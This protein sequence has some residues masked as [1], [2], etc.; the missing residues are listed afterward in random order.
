MT[1]TP[2]HTNAI[3]L[4]HPPNPPSTPSQIKRQKIFVATYTNSNAVNHVC[5]HPAPPAFTTHAPNLTDS[6]L[7]SSETKFDLM[8]PRNGSPDHPTAALL[9]QYAAD[10]CPVDC[11]QP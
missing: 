6:H 9:S 5:K 2:V 10:G 7:N 3:P 11:G 8:H 4:C 1:A